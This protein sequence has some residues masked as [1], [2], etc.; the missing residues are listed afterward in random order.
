MYG[1]SLKSDRNIFFFFKI[2][3]L[4]GIL[5]MVLEIKYSVSTK[6]RETNINIIFDK[7]L[8]C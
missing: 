1:Y 4:H 5:K 7:L 2:S 8:F 3:Q 6:K